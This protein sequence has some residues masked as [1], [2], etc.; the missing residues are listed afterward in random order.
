MYAAPR[1]YLSEPSDAVCISSV[2]GAS[3]F[4]GGINF[5]IEFHM[6]VISAECGV[7]WPRFSRS[8][9]GVKVGLLLSSL[10]GGGD[11]MCGVSLHSVV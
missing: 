10:L 8:D 6:S 11:G 3:G 4:S 1:R 5:C 9:S 2:S 7:A